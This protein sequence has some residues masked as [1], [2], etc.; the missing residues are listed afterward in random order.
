MKKRRFSF[1]LLF[2]IIIIII[3]ILFHAFSVNLML[4]T[5]YNIYST[6]VIT[7]II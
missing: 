4:V 3:I 6:D 5:K 7:F 2:R 1:L